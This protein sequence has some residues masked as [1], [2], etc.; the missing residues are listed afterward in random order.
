MK[1]VKFILK[2]TLII[3]FIFII[4]GQIRDLGFIKNEY[5]KKIENNYISPY[6]EQ[7]WSMFSPNP[8]TGNQYIVLSF[9]CK[10]NNLVLDIH[11]QVRKGSIFS[12]L[13]INQRLL[14]YQSEC[15]ND[16]LTKIELKKIILNN[17]DSRKSHGL[18]S[19]LNY[20][21]IALIKQSVFLKSINSKDSI[22][23][24]IY[25]VDHPLNPPKS[26]KFLGEKKFIKL[27][28]IFLGTK[29]E[30]HKQFSI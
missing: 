30:L 8:P 2:S 4:T 17:V 10:N 12:F 3:H 7:N 28:N 25:L 22:T 27:E 23:T 29:N 16:I 1:Y 18:Q 5:T 24:D 21:K 19:I 14:K 6:F 20:A 11:E 26:K 15:Y 9:R 13:N